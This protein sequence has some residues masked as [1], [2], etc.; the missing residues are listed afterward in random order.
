MGEGRQHRGA[1]RY[2]SQV[3]LFLTV[4]GSQFT[5]VC[6][7]SLLMAK[8]R[9]TFFRWGLVGWITFIHDLALTELGNNSSFS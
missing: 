8:K 7:Q 5:A 4:V 6:T 1:L 3:Y 9:H 2:Y